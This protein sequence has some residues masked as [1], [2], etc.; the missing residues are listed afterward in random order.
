MDEKIIAS[1]TLR[2]IIVGMF[3]GFL[4]VFQYVQAFRCM[5]LLL[6]LGELLGSRRMVKISGKY[7]PGKLYLRLGSSDIRVYTKIFIAREYEIDIEGPVRTIVDAG[8]NN[9]YSVVYLSE[10]YP[11]ARIVALEPDSSNYSI[12]KQNTSSVESVTLRKCALWSENT[13]LE[14]IPRT[15]GEWGSSI[16][17][18]AD[19]IPG[20]G[21]T[22][23]GLSMESLLEAEGLAE[24][25]LLK[26][27][28]EGSEL[29]IFRNS[30]AWIDKVRT[31]I[32]ELHDR[33]KP[34]CE[35]EFYRAVDGFGRV[36]R[37]GEN[38]VATRSGS[39]GKRYP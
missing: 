38:A 9:G 34:G 12:L 21:T 17:R 27:D 26:M 15:T 5:G 25:D 10:R 14:L 4:R 28:I 2:N 36:Y 22:V 6:A 35:R 33:L 29:E 11:G 1:K 16:G 19:S 30:Q 23:E 8:A 7:H 18:H 13:S 24:L 31:I 39:E 3:T 37:N 20:S 32:C